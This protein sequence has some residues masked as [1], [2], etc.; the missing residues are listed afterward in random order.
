MM[1]WQAVSRLDQ[2]DGE[3]LHLWA[4]MESDSKLSDSDCEA[5]VNALQDIS[6]PILR[7]IDLP[8]DWEH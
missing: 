1:Y 5:L 4:V 8:E 3:Y 7:Y 2:L 6:A